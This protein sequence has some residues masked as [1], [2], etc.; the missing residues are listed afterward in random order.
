MSYT[1][2]HCENLQGTINVLSNQITNAWY[3]FYRTSLAK[4]VYI[5]FKYSNGVNSA[6]FNSFVTAG[7]LYANGVSNTQHGVTVYNLTEGASNAD[8][9]G[10]EDDIIPN[11]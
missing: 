7:Y 11:M 4:N 5:P 1:F 8:S 10:K 6:T 9:G 2:S 3:C